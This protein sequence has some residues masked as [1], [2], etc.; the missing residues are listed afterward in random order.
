[1]MTFS[2]EIIRGV[3]INTNKSYLFPYQIM[4]EILNNKNRVYYCR[5]IIEQVEDFNSAMKIY[6]SNIRKCRTVKCNNK[7]IADLL[8]IRKITSDENFEFEIIKNGRFN[9]LCANVS[10]ID[11][12]VIS[13][14]G[15]PVKYDEARKFMSDE[16][17]DTMENEFEFSSNQE[18]Y[19]AYE[20]CYRKK[21]KTEYSKDFK[22]ESSIL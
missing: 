10:M 2:I 1:M 3:T 8:Y 16:L 5:K 4:L 11:G 9:I 6:K 20:N 21:Y 17:L 19:T 7:I 22:L 12:Y 13:S 18:F 15:M 14:T